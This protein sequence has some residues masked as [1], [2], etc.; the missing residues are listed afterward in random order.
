MEDKCAPEAAL[1]LATVEA[2][3]SAFGGLLRAS[4][5]T[6]AEAA[7]TSRVF[8][9]KRALRGHAMQKPQNVANTRTFHN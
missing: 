1:G 5:E 7:N 4:S 9:R 6:T 8:H 3:H 2:K